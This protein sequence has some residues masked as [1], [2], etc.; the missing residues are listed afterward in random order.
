V[1]NE[2]KQEPAVDA[3]HG[4]VHEAGEVG[5]EVEEHAGHLAGAAGPAGV[6]ALMAEAD[7]SLYD[8]K[9]LRQQDRPGGA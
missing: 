1:P 8:L 9:R 6:D 2:S 5:G 4:A 3:D 7:R